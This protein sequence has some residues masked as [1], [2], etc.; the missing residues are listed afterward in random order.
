MAGNIPLVGFHDFLSV[1]ILGHRVII[2]MSSSDNVLIKMI[3]EQLLNL[4]PEFYGKIAF[5][6][7][8]KDNKFDAV[9]A[10]GSDNSAKYFQYY[11]KNIKQIIRK[12][13]RSIAII[14]GT[15]SN[16]Q[17]KGL[18]DDIFSYFGLGCRNISKVFIK[19]GYDL[20]KLFEV[21]YPYKEIIEH[22][23]YRNNY[24]YNKAVFLMGKNQLIENGFLLMKK[25]KSLQSPV[26]M[27]YYEYYDQISTVERYIEE[28]VDQLQCIVSKKNTSFGSAQYPS[29]L[30]YADGIDTI[31][32]L[33]NW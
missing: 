4:A 26:A 2:K 9:I 3:I 27:L 33:K 18:A 19:N 21:F 7:N 11:F 29:L 24:D 22:K 30:D 31:E 32:F 23:K 13:R 6:D 14:E 16:L 5:V 28:N 12:N 17:L 10:T 8:L 25:D 15:E 20:D 1:L